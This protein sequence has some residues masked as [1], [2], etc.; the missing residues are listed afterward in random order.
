M[1]LLRGC[2]VCEFHHILRVSQHQSLRETS[3]YVSIQANLGFRCGDVFH[4][5]S[6]Y[7]PS[8]PN[9]NSY[10]LLLDAKGGSVFNIHDFVTNALN[11]TES[12][13]KLMQYLPITGNV[14]LTFRDIIASKL[15][16]YLENEMPQ[17]FT[18]TELKKDGENV[19]FDIAL[20]NS[21]SD[22]P[23]DVIEIKIDR[24]NHWTHSTLS[25]KVIEDVK[26]MLKSFHNSTDINYWIMVLNYSFHT[27]NPDAYPSGYLKYLQFEPKDR[28][29]NPDFSLENLNKEC[30]EKMESITKTLA[31][32]A[33]TSPFAI[34]ESSTKMLASG[35]HRGVL[36]R[37][38]LL[39]MRVSPDWNK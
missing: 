35:V 19:R 34:R 23:T 1:S 12:E 37:V 2:V 24:H 38:D 4:C 3:Q 20:R 13:A 14:E 31:D 10:L 28:M 29:K 17:L 5:H 32:L 9:R 21:E 11:F 36:T 18:F 15:D 27:S 7:L 39:T 26:K 6:A 8:L 30:S 16:L 33:A 22:L 25:K